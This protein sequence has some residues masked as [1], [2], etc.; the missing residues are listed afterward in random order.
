MVGLLLALL[1]AQDH[2]PIEVG[3]DRLLSDSGPARPLAESQLSTSP[4]NPNQLLAV[5]IQ[6]DY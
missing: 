6:N 4:N 5:V 3:G 2:A 1:Q